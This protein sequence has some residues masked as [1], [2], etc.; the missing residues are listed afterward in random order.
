MNADVDVDK[1]VNVDVDEGR[2]STSASELTFFGLAI[3]R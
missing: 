1:D 3:G 2:M